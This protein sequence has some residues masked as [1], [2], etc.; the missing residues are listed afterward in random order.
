MQLHPSSPTAEATANAPDLQAG[1]HAAGSRLRR[2]LVWS[3]AITVVVL[4]LIFIPPLVSVSHYQRQIARSMSDSLGRPVHLDKATLHLLPVPGLTLS[5]LVVSEDPAFGAEPTIRAN[6][7]EATLRLGSLWRRRVEFSTVHFIEPSVN[8]VRNAQGR[9]NLADVLLHGSH[10]DTAPTGQRRA[11]PTPRFP[12][13]E[14]TGGRVNIKLGE[15]KLPFSLTD[16]DFALWLPT[17]NQWRVRL[18]AQPARTDTSIND[19]GVLRFDGNLRRA[20]TAPG[21]P[22]NLSVSWHDA[23]LGE[24]S[25]LITGNDL[26]WRGT[27]NLDA[28]VSGTLSEAQLETKLTLGSLRRAEFAPAQPLDLQISCGASLGA[29]SVSLRALRC[30]MPDSAPQ[31]M[32]LTSSALDLAHPDQADATVMAGDVPLH[33]G[34]LWAALFSARVPTNLH[35]AGTVDLLLQHRPPGALGVPPAP[36]A[37]HGRFKLAVAHPSA[38]PVTGNQWNGTVQ[39]HLPPPPVAAPGADAGTTKPNS[40]SIPAGIELVWRTAAATAAK[41]TTAAAPA[42]VMQ[43]VSIPLAPNSGL[44]VMAAISATGYTVSAVGTASAAAMLLPARYLPQLGDGLEGVLPFP[45]TG[46][47]TS[48]VDFTCSH[49]WGA[50]QTCTPLRP[51]VTTGRPQVLLPAGTQ[52]PRTPA[53]LQPRSLSPLDHDPQLGGQPLQQPASQSPHL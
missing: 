53:L 7:V 8:L 44:N 17:A 24:A 32:V 25:R 26:G 42:L 30:S 33:W 3:A 5:N 34:L 47:Q 15:N 22:L 2:R 31:P 13:I 43:P 36:K 41:V 4:L 48:R 12:Y 21:I 52:Q 1:T 16:A 50:L 10:V 11:G 6:T 45:P 38:P 20:E 23:P 39:I 51:T 40:G 37:H 27:L 28:T 9:W 35:P 18:Q 14:A 46:L 19:P 29:A 49:P